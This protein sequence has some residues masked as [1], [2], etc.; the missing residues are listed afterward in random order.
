MKVKLYKPKAIIYFHSQTFVAILI[1]EKHMFY[2]G[3][4][5]KK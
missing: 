2:I 4:A 1:N 3:H 5:Q